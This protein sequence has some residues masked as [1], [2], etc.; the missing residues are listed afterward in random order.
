MLDNWITKLKEV[1]P[2]VQIL[3]ARGST[4]FSLVIYYGIFHFTLLTFS[5]TR[6]SFLPTA[7]IY[8]FLIIK[9]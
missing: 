3:S 5:L 2:A 7:T 4:S 9:Q 8:P 1:L 6:Y